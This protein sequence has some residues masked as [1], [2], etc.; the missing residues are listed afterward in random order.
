MMA[1]RIKFFE[2][3]QYHVN[4]STNISYKKGVEYLVPDSI[5]EQVIA[6]EKAELVKDERRKSKG[7]SSIPETE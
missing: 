7:P 6:I 1:K 3:Y 4:R 2:D 5:A